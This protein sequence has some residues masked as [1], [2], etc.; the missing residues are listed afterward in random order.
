[1]ALRTR[2]EQ[3]G[4]CKRAGTG[5]SAPSNK[6]LK[7]TAPSVTE[8][9]SLALCST[10]LGAMSKRDQ[11]TFPCAAC[12]FVVLPEAYGSY[13]ICPVC[14]WEDDPVQLAN[15]C[16][17]GGA[18]DQSLVEAQTSAITGLPLTVTSHNGFTRV[19][20]WRPLTPH[21]IARFAAE[22]PGEKWG[23]RAIVDPAEAYW[24][25]RCVR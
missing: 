15:P 16:S 17:G 3:T 6:A 13:D 9:C 14:G 22:H 25:K 12:G 11:P 10:D 4:T 19:G 21:E 20:D 23:S 18:N 5:I 1:M 24:A 8:R 7:L 2:E